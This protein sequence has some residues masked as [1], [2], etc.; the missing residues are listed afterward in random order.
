MTLTVLNV[1]N[2][3]HDIT[4][5]INP[6]VVDGVTMSCSASLIQKIS[7]ATDRLCH[8]ALNQKL[9]HKLKKWCKFSS[10]DKQNCIK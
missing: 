3:L 8:T 7:E 5:V 6:H 10:C 9:L 2:E 4:N 1:L